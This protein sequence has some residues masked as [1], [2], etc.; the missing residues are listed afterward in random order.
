MAGRCVWFIS[1]NMVSLTGIHIYYNL[2]NNENALAPKL[3]YRHSRILSLRVRHK[4]QRV[5]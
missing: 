4:I 3:L 1:A 5:E 2:V